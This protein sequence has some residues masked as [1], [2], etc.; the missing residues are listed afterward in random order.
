MRDCT[1]SAES[2]YFQFSRRERLDPQS[3]L[4]ADFVAFDLALGRN[5]FWR[6]GAT[7]GAGGHAFGAELTLGGDL[8]LGGDVLAFFFCLALGGD[9]FL[10]LLLLFLLVAVVVPASN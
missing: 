1:P 3:F 2:R 7:F 10:L 6:C 9:L 4:S 8:A 5:L